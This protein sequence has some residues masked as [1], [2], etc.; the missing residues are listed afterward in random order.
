M[1]FLAW[2]K[3]SAKC[4]YQQNTKNLFCFSFLT[5]LTCR[6]TNGVCW[7]IMYCGI[8]NKFSKPPTVTVTSY[9]TQKQEVKQR[10]MC[11][12]EKHR[13]MCYTEKHRSMCYTEKH[14]SMCYTEKLKKATVHLQ[15]LLNYVSYYKQ[16]ICIYTDCSYH[17]V[18]KWYIHRLFFSLYYMQVI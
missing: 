10:S 8:H 16:V 1:S 15:S 5:F 6:L 7:V 4:R 14:R 11:Y 13:S 9:I 3:E 17:T 18:C 2:T 12:T